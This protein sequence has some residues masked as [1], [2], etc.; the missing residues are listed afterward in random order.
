MPDDN[1][2]DDEYGDHD[3]DKIMKITVKK[4]ITEI[5]FFVLVLLFAHFQRLRGLRN[6]FFFVIIWLATM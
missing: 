3:N 2:F 1:D 4:T 6:S 5:R